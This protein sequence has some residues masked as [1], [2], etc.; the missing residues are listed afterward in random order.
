MVDDGCFE[1]DVGQAR[2]AGWQPKCLGVAGEEEQ[3]GRAGGSTDG[4][5]EWMHGRRGS[6]RAREREK[7]EVG[8]KAMHQAPSLTPLQAL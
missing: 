6:E 4:G 7:R 3:Q 8:E 1:N 2:I 5:E